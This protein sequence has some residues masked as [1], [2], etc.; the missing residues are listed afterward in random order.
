MLAKK[1]K[2]KD[3]RVYIRDWIPNNIGAQGAGEKGNIGLVIGLPSTYKFHLFLN[4][5]KV[6]RGGIY[7]P[8]WRK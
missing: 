3:E 6:V 2:E 4:V 7:L 8:F 5:R 1:T